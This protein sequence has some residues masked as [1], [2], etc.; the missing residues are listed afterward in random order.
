MI[1]KTEHFVIA[2]DIHFSHIKLIQQN[3]ILFLFD[4]INIFGS[5]VHGQ[6]RKQSDL[7]YYYELFN[8]YKCKRVIY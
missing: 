6:I 3:I 4:Y 7:F 5:I 8:K 1:P 2:M